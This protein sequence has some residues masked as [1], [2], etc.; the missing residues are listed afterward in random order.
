MVRIGISG[1]NY[2]SWR[3]AFYPPDLPQRCE[4]AYASRVFASIEVNATFYSLKT[5]ASFRRWHDETPEDFV[6]ALKSSRFISHMKKLNEVE[7]PLATFF[8]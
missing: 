4:L 3:G 7:Q 5:P 2:P 6:F 8:A 1:W